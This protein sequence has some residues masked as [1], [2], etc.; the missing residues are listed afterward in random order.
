MNIFAYYNHNKINTMY[1]IASEQHSTTPYK[2][3]Y[4]KNQILRLT[5]NM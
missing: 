3:R 4:L 5:A 1:A 2:S